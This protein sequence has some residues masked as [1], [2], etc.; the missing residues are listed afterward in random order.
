LATNEPSLGNTSCQTERRTGEDTEKQIKK[1]GSHSEKQ[2]E[3]KQVITLKIS[4]THELEATKGG[5]CED[6]E[7]KRTS[8]EHSLAGER[9][10]TDK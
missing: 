7:R 10:P 4:N 1:M 2:R 8:E 3:D 9:R 6:T 5:R